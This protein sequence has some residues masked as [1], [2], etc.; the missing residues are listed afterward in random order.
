MVLA[1]GDALV[2][3]AEVLVVDSVDEEIAVVMGST[4]G[5]HDICAGP[6]SPGTP[7]THVPFP[8]SSPSCCVRFKKTTAS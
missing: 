1:I 2:L 5:P 7:E 8:P 4:Q 3:L 6:E